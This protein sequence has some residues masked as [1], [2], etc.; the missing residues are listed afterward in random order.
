MFTRLSVLLTVALTALFAP[1]FTTLARADG[2]INTSGSGFGANVSQDAYGNEQDYISIAWYCWERWGGGYV[3]YSV[4]RL[5]VYK[6]VFGTQVGSNTDY[7]ISGYVNVTDFNAYYL[8]YQNT[9]SL[10]WTITRPAWPTDT[11][12][13]TATSCTVQYV[14]DVTLREADGDALSG[15]SYY[16]TPTT[17][18]SR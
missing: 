7:P 2:S 10:Y 15:Y 5:F 18:Y 16:T 14:Y 3:D 8:R 9:S 6:D 13:L 17:D 1:Q 11:A 4:R 12:G